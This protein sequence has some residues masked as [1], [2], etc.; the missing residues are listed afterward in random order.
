VNCTG[1]LLICKEWEDE[2]LKWKKSDFNLNEVVIEA[3][4]IWVP[5]FAIING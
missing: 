3:K 5:E 4:N 1:N 2:R